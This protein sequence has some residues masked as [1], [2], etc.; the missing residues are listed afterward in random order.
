METLT[1]E[2][3]YWTINLVRGIICTVY[4]VLFYIFMSLLSA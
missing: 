3:K 2:E 1:K 4:A